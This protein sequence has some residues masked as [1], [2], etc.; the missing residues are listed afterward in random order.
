MEMEETGVGIVKEAEV[1]KPRVDDDGGNGESGVIEE[2]GLRKASFGEGNEVNLNVGVVIEND[3]Q[4]VKSE[5]EMVKPRADDGDKGRLV[6]GGNG[7]SS[8]KRTRVQGWV[9]VEQVVLGICSPRGD[10]ALKKIPRS[11]KPRSSIKRRKLSDIE[12]CEQTGVGEIPVTETDFGEKDENNVGEG[13]VKNPEQSLE[14]NKRRRKN[15]LGDNDNGIK[16]KRLGRLKGSKN[17]KKICPSQS[18]NMVKEHGNGENGP[19]SGLHSKESGF[20]ELD[21][22]LVGEFSNGSLNKKSNEACEQIWVAE[23]SSMHAGFGEKDENKV[24]EGSNINPEQSLVKKKRRKNVLGDNDNAIKVKRLGRPKGSENKKKI[25]PTQSQNIVEEH[26]NG[27]NDNPVSGLDLKESGSV[28]QDQQHVGESPDG[29]LNKKSDEVC[30]QV[31]V[32]EISS[33]HA[34][35]GEK[36]ENNVGEGSNINPEQSLVKKKRRKNVLGDNDNAIK[37][38]RPGRPKGSENKKKI[39]PT[40]SQNIVEEHGNGENDN[41][42]SGLD[43]K[44]SGSVE[45]DQQHVGE[46]P[47]GPLSKKSDEACEQVGVAEISS[48]D[49]GFGE[50]DANKVG[51][52]S[53]KNPE[54]SLE[55][56]KRRRKTVLGDSDTGIK[57]ERRGRPKGSKSKK[58][59]SPSQSQNMVKEH[60][61]GEN[62]NPASGLDSKESGFVEQDQKHVGESPDG[63]LNKKSDEVCEQ[64]GVG[65]ISSMHAGFAEKD[66]NSVGEGFNKIPE[67]SLEKK[68]RRRGKAVQGDNGTGIKVRRG[69]K[70]GTKDKKKRVRRCRRL[71]PGGVIPSQLQTKVERR[72]RPKGRKDSKKRKPYSQGLGQSGISQSQSMVEE[73][74]DGENEN[75]ISGSDMKESGF[76]EQDQNRVGEPSNGSSRKKLQVKRRKMAVTTNDGTNADELVASGVDGETDP[77][78]AGNELQLVAAVREDQSESSENFIDDDYCVVEDQN[79]TGK[80]GKRKRQRSCRSTKG[81][82]RKPRVIVA[83]EILH[84]SEGEGC[85]KVKT[86]DPRRPRGRPKKDNDGSQEVNGESNAVVSNG[87]QGSMMCHQCR[88]NVYKNVI[89]CS[90]CKR[91]RYCYGC[92]AT[93]Y[94]GRTKKEVEVAC[95]YCRGNCNCRA[96]LHANV[97]VQATHKEANED[98][99]LQRSLYLLKR[100][101]PLLKHLQAEQ[102]RELVVESGIRGVELT[103]EHVPKASFDDDDRVYCDNCNTSIVN[104]HRSCPSPDCSYDICLY[105]CRELREGIQPGGTEAESS[106]QH[107]VENSQPQGTHANR[108][109]FGWKADFKAEAS[110]AD[111]SLDFPIWKENTNGSIPCPPKARGGCGN[112]MLELRRIFEA[113]WVDELVEKSEALTSNFEMPYTE[114]VCSICHNE[115]NDDVIR[116]SAS[117]S[118]SYDNFLYCPNAIDLEEDDFEHFQMHWRR[119]EPVIVKNVEKKTCGLSWDPRVMIRAFRTAKLKLKEENQCVKA[120]DCLDLCEVEIHLNHF[121]RGYEEGRRHQNGWPEMLK[122]KDW[123]PTNSFDEYLPRHCAEFIAMLPYSD[124]THPVSGLLNLATKLPDG[125]HRPDLGPKSYIAY[126]FPEELGRGDSVTKLHCDISDAV[127]IL[128]HS[129]KVKVSSTE[130]KNIA[131]LQKKYK[132]EDRRVTLTTKPPTVSCNVDSSCIQKGDA[133]KN[134]A[135][136]VEEI[137]V[138]GNLNNSQDKIVDSLNPSTSGTTESNRNEHDI[139]LS[140]NEPSVS[141]SEMGNEDSED[142]IPQ[143]VN[144]YSDSEYG[145]ALWDIFRRE[146]V[147]KLTEY[148]N[149]HQKEFR[150]INNAP[151]S[152]VVHPIHDQTFYFDEK[153]KRKL[154]KE[155]GVEPWTFEQYLGE[156]VFIPAGCPHQVRNRQ[157]CIKVALDFVSPDNVGECIRLTEEFRLLPKAHRSKEDKLEQSVE[158]RDTLS[159]EQTNENLEQSVEPKKESPTEQ[160]IDNMEQSVEPRE[161]P[162]IEQ[163]NENL[164][165]SVGQREEHP[166]EQ[167][168]ENLVQSVEP[169][170]DPP[171][172]QANE[173]VVQV[174]PREGDMSRDAS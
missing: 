2:G 173:S 146:D 101:L 51:D 114:E 104:F 122:L 45:Q 17:K 83:G 174:D 49:T 123:P 11:R 159:L 109:F 73:H 8:V 151:V 124:Y 56:K 155:F 35:F 33:M 158:A 81:V 121:F 134:E 172:A 90:N 70:K 18:Q 14:K 53:N 31:G 63:S 157:S 37:V 98:I 75:L 88:L 10:F 16:V 165:Q 168:N 127:N 21:Q 160:A 38:K 96:C 50:K 95:P 87:H 107:F 132:D 24:G 163:A 94:P 136:K 36:D 85:E 138:D 126:G 19:A 59:I 139:N 102:R 128:I 79:H 140:G 99:R 55:K 72:G 74:G 46:S 91:R 108:Q 28:E 166:T 61:N 167:T 153:H 162:L 112:G 129:T 110:I 39:S 164:A 47:H 78:V 111:D 13:S 148:L 169:K 84:Y 145:G 92:I 93:W 149:K 41:P 69:R 113:N 44:E 135:L 26:G 68:K 60:G 40:Q 117:R 116:K 152:S 34:G 15:V 71:G 133:D 25:S 54:Q 150:G 66:E 58:K 76:A 130:L 118:G 156:A 161:K 30:E 5:N 65:E 80:A 97:I 7:E 120:I 125:S 32:A 171:I 142:D 29:P 103:E 115:E 6:S 144:G 67:Q 147:P 82:R 9:P 27:E 141:G 52:G 119:G 154:K 42:V 131:T 137:N 77:L 48:K 1:A 170:E 23:I 62:G 22:K 143:C 20:V 105:C 3:D 86:V 4:N 106:F 43:L 100:T 64:V 57:V 12:A 89:F